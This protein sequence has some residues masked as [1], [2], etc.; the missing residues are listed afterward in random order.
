MLVIITG[1]HRGITLCQSLF[2]AQAL[3]SRERDDP[4]EGAHARA[5]AF[6]RFGV[7][8]QADAR[9]PRSVEPAAVA[10]H[11]HLGPVAERDRHREFRG[12]A[13]RIFALGG[14]H[15]DCR[16]PAGV[17][18]R[19]QVL[20]RR[21]PPV[22]L[23]RAR[24]AHAD[25]S[26]DGAGARGPRQGGQAVRSGTPVPGPLHGHLRRPVRRR[27]AIS[28]FVARPGASRSRWSASPRC[29]A[30]TPGAPSRR[31]AA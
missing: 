24:D 11:A 13:G 29:T 23:A 10:G 28:P 12:A 16:R 26:R 8:R 20:R 1:A 5:H 31:C 9:A 17:L 30:P 6:R 15:P 4:R 27:T 25:L 22:P 18:R 21:L 7:L 3:A 2:K 14:G 19:D